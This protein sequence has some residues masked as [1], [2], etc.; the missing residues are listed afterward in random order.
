MKYIKTFE[1]FVN[2]NYQ[3]KSF[4]IY[5]SESLDNEEALYEFDLPGFWEI[6]SAGAA[7]EAGRA[8]GALALALLAMGGIGFTVGLLQIKD[9]ISELIRERKRVKGAAEGQDFLLKNPKIQELAKISKELWK[10]QAGKVDKRRKDWEEKLSNLKTIAKDLTKKRQEIAK[11]IAAD[12]KEAGLSKEAVEYLGTQVSYLKT[13]Y[14]TKTLMK[15]SANENSNFDYH[16]NLIKKAEDYLALNGMESVGEI[17]VF[18]NNY[19]SDREIRPDDKKLITSLEFFKNRL[20][21]KPNPKSTELGK[22]LV[23]NKLAE[24]LNEAVKI[25]RRIKSKSDIEKYFWGSDKTHAEEIWGKNTTAIL[26][27]NN[28]KHYW[29]SY[30][31]KDFHNSWLELKVAKPHP[32]KPGNFLP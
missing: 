20:G 26:Q 1:E 29:V 21:E 23:K 30:K 14:F 9:K 6:F 24:S 19:L 5:E 2:E 17:K 31:F 8:I 11:E 32:S 18:V 15:E 4:E 25:P 3:V 10:A 13:S 27:A 7:W 28:G 12:I 22:Y 16:I